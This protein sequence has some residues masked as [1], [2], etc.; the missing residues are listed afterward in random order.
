MQNVGHFIDY[1]LL[2]FVQNQYSYVRDTKDFINKVQNISIP[3]NSYLLVFDAK[4]MYQN[5]DFEEILTAVKTTLINLDPTQYSIKIPQREIIIDLLHII[6]NNN[7]FTFEGKMYRQILGIPMG[8][9]ASGELADL[10]MYQIFEN[11]LRKYKHKK[12]ILYEIQR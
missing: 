8:G 3:P 2:P 6:L 5:L 4:N 10:R 11:I 1:I 9:S 7:E 12:S